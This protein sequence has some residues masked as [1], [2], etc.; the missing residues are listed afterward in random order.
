MR[1]VVVTLSVTAALVHPVVAR[2]G[3][4]QASAPP[5]TVTLGPLR[6]TPGLTIQEVGV[7]NNVFDEPVNPKRDYTA[8]VSAHADVTF[9]MRRLRL[10]YSTST[11]Y[12]YYQKYRSERGTNVSSSARLD[13]DAG[14]LKPYAAITGLNT[15]SRLNSEVDARARHRDLAYAAGVAF[16]IASRTNVVVN[17]TQSRVAYDPDASFRGVDL[18]ES[19]NGRRQS[20]DGGAA[21]ALTPLTTL[22]TSVGREQQRFALAPGRNSDSWRLTSSLSFSPSGL[23]TGS[24]NVGYRR[25]H[26]LSAALPDYSGLVSQVGVGMTIYGRHQVQVGFVRDVQYSY[27]IATAYYLGTGGTV[28]WTYTLG[29]PIDVRGTAGHTLMDYSVAGGPLG[30]DN[31]TT[32]GGGVGYR[33]STRARLGLNAQW[34]R[35]DSNRSAE[36][37]YRNHRIFAGLTWGIS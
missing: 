11:D 25:F 1:R 20:V 3:Q 2:A 5:G 4:D 24:A 36:R 14:R 31:L 16:R 32:Y 19:F 27:E 37:T 21:I 18:R 35:R 26:P 6:I 22:T 15:R 10:G 12:V 34:S 23:V 33:F 29:G 8:T 13:F 30:Q 28:T 17:G 7:D 9:R